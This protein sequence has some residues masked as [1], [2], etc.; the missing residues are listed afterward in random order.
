MLLQ[1]SSTNMGLKNNVGIASACLSDARDCLSLWYF[2]HLDSTILK[3]FSLDMCFGNIQ[4]TRNTMCIVSLVIIY[5]FSCLV[6]FDKRINAN[7]LAWLPASPG[8]CE[9]PVR[10]Y[11]CW[12]H[13]GLI[14]K[15]MGF[16]KRAVNVRT[17]Y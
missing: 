7:N 9:L 6:K 8:L 2:C 1:I 3:S 15:R 17:I 14:V 5:R 16:Y 10:L 12:G 4:Q 11:A 13:C